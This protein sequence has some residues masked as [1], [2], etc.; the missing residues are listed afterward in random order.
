[1]WSKAQAAVEFMI[2][3]L[4]LVSIMIVFTIYAGSKGAE[5]TAA[6]SKLKAEEMGWQISN[7]INT[8]MYS[9]GYYTEFDLPRTIE[10]NNYSL[11]VT[12]NTVEM[13]YNGHSSIYEITVTNITFR[14]QLR[15]G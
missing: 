8:A 1:M 3:V 9:R 6:Q 7:L 2:C 11:T 5:K 12:N 14:V 13:E 4:V 10:G 15:L